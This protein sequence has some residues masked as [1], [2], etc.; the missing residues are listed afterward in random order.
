MNEAEQ[1]AMIDSTFESFTG[2]RRATPTPFLLTRIMAA[3]DKGPES[4]AWIKFGAFISRPA[5]AWA[6]IAL[7]V[8]LNAG[9]LLLNAKQE[10]PT[11]VT[12]QNSTLKDDF[13]INSFSLYESENQ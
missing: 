4:S 8:F 2:A 3:L 7:V 6:T 13:A 12:E 1:K 10:Q 9:I 11:A 5:V